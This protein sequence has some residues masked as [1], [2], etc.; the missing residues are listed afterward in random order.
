MI[1]I[2]WPHVLIDSKQGTWRCLFPVGT[3]LSLDEMATKRFVRNRST[4]LGNVRVFQLNRL[5]FFIKPNQILLHTLCLLFYP[6]LSPRNI[7]LIHTFFAQFSQMSN[8]FF[9]R[10]VVRYNFISI[11][12]GRVFASIIWPMWLEFLS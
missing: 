10:P 9:V 1:I 2:D 8:L 4:Q 5:F 3:I 7:P 6:F 12:F 11:C